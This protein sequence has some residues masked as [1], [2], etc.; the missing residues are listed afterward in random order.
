M[1]L[2]LALLPFQGMDERIM[3]LLAAQLGEKGFACTVLPEAAIPP[4]TYNQLRTQ[5]RVERLLEATRQ[6]VAGRVLG[7][8]DLDLYAK[9]F[10]YVFG[11]ADRLGRA[12][13]IS[14]ARLR[15]SADEARFQ[16]RMLKE[17]VHELGHTLGLTHCRQPDCVMHFSNTLADTDRKGADFCAECRARLAALQVDL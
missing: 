15:A 6:A 16:A 14:V 11:M 10:N 5:Y 17:A 9:G 2:P 3:A 13:V 4:E 1:T 7:V 8:A 12:A